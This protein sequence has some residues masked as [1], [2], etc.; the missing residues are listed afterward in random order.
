MARFFNTTGPC[1]PARHYMLPAE[2][3]LPELLGLVEREQYFVLHAP[4]QT[5]KT[6]AMMAFAARLRGLGYA[7]VW[8]SLEESQGEE[9]PAQAERVWVN[10]LRD[11]AEGQ[12][13]ADQQMPH[14][15][16]DGAPGT[17]LRSQLRV[18]ARSVAAPIVLL[19][20]E[21]D[22]V[23]G[24]ALVSL[25]RQL[26]N[27]F[28]TRGA[29]QFPVSVVLIGMRDLRD[30][31]TTAK[32]G[33]PTNPG[34]PFNV[35][36]VSLTLRTFTR[37]EVGAL[38]AQHEEQTGQ[39]FSSAVTDRIF[40]YTQGQPFLV[41][42][43]AD[44][45]TTAS[46]PPAALSIE[47]VEAAKE[48]LILSRTTHLDALGERLR[49][50]RVARILAAVIEGLPDYAF[51]LSSDDLL[52]CEDLGLLR[53]SPL[54]EVANPLYREVLVRE[55][56]QRVQPPIPN[57]PWLHSD[58]RLNLPL[59][60]DSFLSFWRRHAQA[61]RSKDHGPYQEIV[62]HLVFMAWL[63]RIVNGGGRITREY[64]LGRGRLDLLIELAGETHAI[65]IK[66]VGPHESPE[67][68]E[69]EGIE[70]LDRYLEQLGLSEGYLLLFDERPGRTWEERLWRRS[71]A[72]NGRTLHLRGA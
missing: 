25:L 65:E 28:S 49:E 67:T 10:I 48:R 13:P 26:R 14:F 1:D 52:Y 55:L 54:V 72:P 69:E 17:L 27:G 56:A 11:A 50:P 53:R 5:G 29:G 16:H 7:A 43:F 8:A 30:Y 60:I 58:G 33:V 63:Q 38:F 21:A 39:S 2:A 46:P 68:V 37:E 3:R 62:P 41:N 31:L 4:R 61:L 45:L 20:D 44:L 6:T 22:V 9:E 34:S 71:P 40:Q 51:D 24:P 32:D 36:K 18:W 15:V 64:A 66:R 19:L 47:Q 57:L 35:K 12:L 59:L 70:Q 23:R 42:A